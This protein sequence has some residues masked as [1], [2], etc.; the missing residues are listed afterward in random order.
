MEIVQVENIVEAA[1]L[2]ANE[3]LSI[4]RLQSLFV[5]NEVEK[6]VLEQVLE[7][8]QQHYKNRGFEL[9]QLASGYRLQVKTELMP[10]VHRLWEEKP[11]RY[12]RALLE[13]LALIAY[14]Q[15]ITRGE[16][17]EVRGVSVSSNIIKTLLE[18]SWIRVIGHRD[19]PGKPALYATTRNFLDYFNLRSLDELPPLSE[20]RDIDAIEAGLVINKEDI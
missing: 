15:P 16:I 9:Q 14:Q 12:S 19:V 3:I 5:E 7:N 13:T 6:K 2:A 18:R 8:L 10:W 1:L 4:D 20:L 11:P 17:E